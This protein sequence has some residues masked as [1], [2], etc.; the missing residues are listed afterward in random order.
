MS[1]F[2][3]GRTTIIVFKNCTIF[4]HIYTRAIS[5]DTLIIK[6]GQTVLKNLRAHKN[7]WPIKNTDTIYIYTYRLAGL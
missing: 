3:F 7:N 6:V 5:N 4:W 1:T 2:F